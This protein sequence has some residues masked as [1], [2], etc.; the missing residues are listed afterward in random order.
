MFSNEV[1]DLLRMMLNVALAS[2]P[3]SKRVLDEFESPQMGSIE[4]SQGGCK[5]Y[6]L[7]ITPWFSDKLKNLSQVRPLATRYPQQDETH[8]D[9]IELVLPFPWNRFDV[10]EVSHSEIE[11]P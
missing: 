3:L 6:G 9:Q 2:L 4:S 8:V 11:R 7:K 10:G 1:H 5:V